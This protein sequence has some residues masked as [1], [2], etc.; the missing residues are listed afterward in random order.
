MNSSIIASKNQDATSCEIKVKAIN[1]KRLK[2]H[3]ERKV[4]FRK[5]PFVGKTL[6]DVPAIGG[7]EGG[8]DAGQALATMFFTFLAKAGQDGFPPAYYLAWIVGDMM[9]RAEEIGFSEMESKPI[10]SRSDEYHSFRGQYMG[11]FTTLCA[12]LT[13]AAQKAGPK[14][15]DIDVGLL[16]KQANAGLGFSSTAKH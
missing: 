16:L 2:F 13:A 11:F 6:W 7:Y 14:L 1:H 12:Y 9:K 5:L 4:E 8:Q 3:A 10:N 15:A